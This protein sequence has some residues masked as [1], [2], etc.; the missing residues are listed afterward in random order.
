MTP[1]E[2][3]EYW[4]GCYKS[5]KKALEVAQKNINRISKLL[6]NVSMEDYVER[7]ADS[8]LAGE[9]EFVTNENWPG[10]SDMGEYLDRVIPSI[11]GKDVRGDR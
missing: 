2:D 1:N 10:A 11:D 4:V 3:F 5:A 7:G 6:G 8:M 9:P